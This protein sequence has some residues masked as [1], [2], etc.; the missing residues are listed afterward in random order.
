M[1]PTN[2]SFRKEN[3]LPNLH[4]LCSMLVFRG[5][6]CSNLLQPGLQKLNRGRRRNSEVSRIMRP[7]LQQ[8]TKM[9]VWKSL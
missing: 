1:E 3:D 2:H 4:D 6:G 5:V 7:R 9:V 8:G